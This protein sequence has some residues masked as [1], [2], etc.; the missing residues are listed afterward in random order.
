MHLL[1]GM[2][3]PNSFFKWDNDFITGNNIVDLQHFKLVELINNLLELSTSNTPINPKT[4]EDICKSISQY[5]SDHFLTEEKL[6][7]KYNIDQRHLNEHV[8]F[9]RDFTKDISTHLSN[10][11]KLQNHDNISILLEYLIRWLAYHI[12]N[13]DKSLIRQINHI[14][15][16]KMTPTEAFEAEE[17][18]IESSTE[19]LLKALKVLYL[20]V[21]KKNREIEKRNIELEEKVK[22]RTA[23]LLEANKKLSQMLFQDTLTGLPNRRY[24]MEHIQ[25]LILKWQKDGI[26]FSILFVDVDNFKTVNDKY[27]HNEGDSVLKWISTFLKSNVSKTDIVC[28]LSGDEF[29]VICPK[30]DQ[31]NAIALG[32]KLNQLCNEHKQ[33]L[34]YWKPSFSIGISTIASNI[35]NP[36]ELLKSADAA[37]YI[38]KSNGGGMSSIQQQ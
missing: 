5:T 21:S 14:S 10:T 15:Y 19:P 2:Y 24:V 35:T 36:S 33:W 17:H 20:L 12:L 3:M 28:R 6:M 23:E 25:R 38:S 18:N 34:E 32:K 26:P 9:H 27:G 37:M 4:V 22:L 16:D 1:G 8:K 31:K 13:V 29:I 11:N 7:K 30:T